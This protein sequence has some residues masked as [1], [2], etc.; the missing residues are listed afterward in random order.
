VQFS[1]ASDAGGSAVYRIG[2]TS[3]LL[4]N[5]ENCNGCGVLGW[6]WQDNA[7]WL[8]QS[9]VVK[10][11]STGTHTIRVQTREDGG[12]ID[13]IL[14]SDATHLS[15]A[16][17][18]LKS[19]STIVP[20][21]STATVSATSTSTTATPYSGTPVSIPGT[22]QAA[23]FDNGSDGVAYHDTTAGNSGSAYRNTNVDL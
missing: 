3:S 22:I 8:A 15:A 23:N 9:A 14:L 7:W 16:P 5:L 21:G 2:T 11:P 10:F 20:K 18:G 1:D 17:G 13:Q 4:V 12:Q 6:G 19:D